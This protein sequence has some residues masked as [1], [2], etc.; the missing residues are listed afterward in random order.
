M[1]T[2]TKRGNRYQARVYLGTE[3]GKKKYAFFS[4]SSRREASAQAKAFEL[5]KD[6][7][8]HNDIKV[9]EAIEEY[10]ENKSAI[11]SP[12]TI[13]AYKTILRQRLQDIMDISILT[14]S[15]KEVQIAI[16]K[17]ALKT[18]PKTVRNTYGLLSAALKVYSISFNIK[19]PQK[20][21]PKI[22]I[23]TTEEIQCLINEARGSEMFLPVLLASALGLRRSEICALKYSDIDFNNQTMSIDKALVP[24]EFGAYEIK[25]TKTTSST[26]VIPVPLN[27]LEQL[28]SSMTRSE[29]RVVTLNPRSI[30]FRFRNLAKKT[31]P[32][33]KIRF[34]DLRHYNASVL[35]ALGVPNKYAMKLMGHSTD[36]MLKTIYQHTFEEKEKEF[37]QE[38]KGFFNT[39]LK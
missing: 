19:L 23:P 35:L 13:R 6:K 7:R 1:A 26:R 3:E 32:G 5:I 21:K 39:N 4:A 16:N 36:N 22:S 33:K 8:K 15:E 28:R 38:I 18:S 25:T 2:I 20:E 12:S 24:N 14:L 10:I 34:H 30:T 11:L 9:S 29:D 31:I 27:V 17:E 37:H